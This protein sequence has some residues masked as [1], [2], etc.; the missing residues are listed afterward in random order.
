MNAL[1]LERK[2]R[3]IKNAIAN[4]LAR[5]VVKLSD[6][7][8]LCQTVQLDLGGTPENPEIR[9]DVERPQ[10][11]GFTSR[12]LDGAEAFVAFL[13][14]QRDHGVVIAVE[15]RRYRL[16]GLEKGEVA[17]FTDED[18][19]IVLKRGGTIEVTCS[20]KFKVNA[21][22]VETS[23]NMKVGGNLEVVG[24]SALKGATTVGTSG[25]NANLVV[26][27]NINGKTITGDTVSDGGKI[28]G[29]HTHDVSL[30]GGTT[31]SSCTAGG[32][33]GTTGG[34]VISGAPN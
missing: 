7:E 26:E 24:T 34:T 12:P 4:L 25:A 33:T 2:L 29:T 3:P 19:K 11:Y 13:G 18:D 31:T 9:A 17:I 15:D 30:T 14:G 5:A 6:D 32:S 27:G 8:K 23:A 1:D 28:L 16:K 21:P 22:I 20:T 10:N